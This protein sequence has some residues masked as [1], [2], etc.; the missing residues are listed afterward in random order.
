MPERCKQLLAYS[1]GDSVPDNEELSDE[2]QAFIDTPRTYEDFKVGLVVPSKL[3]PKR[4]RGGVLLVSECYEMRP[5]QK[6]GIF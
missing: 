6:K 3:K 4:I 2:E 1:F 5:K